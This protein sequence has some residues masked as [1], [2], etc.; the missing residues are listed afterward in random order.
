MSIITVAKSGNA[1]YTTINKAIKNAQPGD[2]IRVHPGVYTESLVIDKLL[3]I[4]GGGVAEGTVIESTYAPC[5][6]MKTDSATFSGF[7]LRQLAVEQD[8]QYPAV[9][10]CQGNLILEDCNITSKSIDCVII[11]GATANP[12]IRGCRIFDSKQ[13]GISIKDN[14]QGTIE[15]C[16]FNNNDFSGIRIEGSSNF[17]IRECRIFD[18]KQNGILIK[19]NRLVNIEN[20]DIYNNIYSGILIKLASIFVVNQCRIFDGKQN[21]IVIKDNSQGTIEDCDIYNN[22]NPGIG[23]KDCSNFIIRKC[24]IFDG[25]QKGIVIKDNSQGAIE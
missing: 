24:R 15:N 1:N 21:G 18:S 12:I 3:E 22:I 9:D 25:K 23:I 11:Q 17:I 20:C 19:D 2:T 4:S 13:N 10:I 8:K 14:S 5:L 16:N 7:C 6:S